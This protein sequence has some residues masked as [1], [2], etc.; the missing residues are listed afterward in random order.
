LQSIGFPVYHREI[1]LTL[2]EPLSLTIFEKRL[3]ADE[4]LFEL[5]A[6]QWRKLPPQ[7]LLEP[8]NFKSTSQNSPPPRYLTALLPPHPYFDNPHLEISIMET[9]YQDALYEIDGLG[10]GEAWREFFASGWQLYWIVKEAKTGV[11]A[12]DGTG[13]A[14]RFTHTEPFTVRQ[15]SRTGKPERDSMNC[16]WK[17]AVVRPWREDWSAF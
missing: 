14:S 11:L 15:N 1:P 7:L 3:A 8:P 12:K 4:L 5:R 16:I 13:K 17:R 2:T 10:Y 6:G 9:D